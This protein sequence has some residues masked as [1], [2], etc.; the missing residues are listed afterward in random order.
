MSSVMVAQDPLILSDKVIREAEKHLSQS[1]KVMARLVIRHGSCQLIHR[2]SNLFYTLTNSIISQQLSSKA[3][4]TIKHRV[5]EIVPTFS[6][7]CFLG[8]PIDTLR[9]A[10]LSSA[11]ARYIFELAKRVSDGRLNFDKVVHQSDEDVITTLTD[12]PGIGRWTAEMFLI[13]GLKRP[14]V[15]ALGDT[16][17]QRSARLLYGDNV[18]L[19]NI[20]QLWRPYRSVASWYLW[21]HL[22]E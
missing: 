4:K 16:G 12:L 6:P 7:D 15:L 11:K 21:R 22:D 5:M 3:A 10:G 9:N 20:G 2:K 14:D 13:F 18:Q 8:V 1:C 19:E 17:L